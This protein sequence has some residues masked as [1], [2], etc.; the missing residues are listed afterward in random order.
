MG[1]G[2]R[3]HYTWAQQSAA[4]SRTARH[5]VRGHA[6]L[7]AVH[8]DDLLSQP[9]LEGEGVGSLAEDGIGAIVERMGGD[10]AATLDPDEAGAEDISW[11]LALQLELCLGKE[12]TGAS[13]DFI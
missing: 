6:R 1:G 2:L 5:G 4:A 7:E 3:G 13:K 12:N 11:E 8:N 9:D 10:D